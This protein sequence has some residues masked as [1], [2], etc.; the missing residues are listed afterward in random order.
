M[1]KLSSTGVS[2]CTR[3][4]NGYENRSRNRRLFFLHHFVVAIEAFVSLPVVPDH[5]WARYFAQLGQIQ[6]QCDM[7]PQKNFLPPDSIQ[8][9][10]PYKGLNF[11]IFVKREENFNFPVTNFYEAPRN[12]QFSSHNRLKYHYLRE[13]QQ[14]LTFLNQYSYSFVDFAHSKTKISGISK[15]LCERQNKF[16]LHNGLINIILRETPKFFTRF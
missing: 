14:F 10:A 13:A 6:G 5:R 1:N 4:P 3:E 7:V 12:F 2:L 15:N 8:K 16:S 11:K 9:L